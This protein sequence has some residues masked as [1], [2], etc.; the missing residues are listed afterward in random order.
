[1]SAHKSIL[2]SRTDPA[3]SRFRTITPGGS[4]SAKLSHTVEMRRPVRT[5]ADGSNR[6]GEV[7]GG[8]ASD[9]DADREDEGVS[10]GAEADRD[11]DGKT[12]TDEE[13]G[14][15]TV[16]EK[17]KKPPTRTPLRPPPALT[18]LLRLADP[19]SLPLTDKKPPTTASTFG[20]TLTSLLAEPSAPPPSSSRP[21]RKRAK[22]AAAATAPSHAILSRSHVRGPPSRAEVALERRAARAVRVE[23]AEKEDRA[24]VRD[25]LEGWVV[26]D[27]SGAG[28]QEVEKGLRKVAQRGGESALLALP[29]PILAPDIARVSWGGAGLIGCGVVIKLF[30]AILEASRAAEEEEEGRGAKGEAGRKSAKGDLAGSGGRDGQGL[31]REGFLDL[32]R[33]G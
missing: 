30:N 19:L 23:K 3:A 28:S 9:A 29:Y 33:K 8:E 17:R 1:M 32:V 14:R 21:P 20:T 11:D 5:P 26:A 15:T 10:P 18:R 6:D 31:T 25:V 4:T 22:A 27:G 24:R 7:D 2:K 12:S 16:G 13:I